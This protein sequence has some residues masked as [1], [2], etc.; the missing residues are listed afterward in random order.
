M[1][2]S[3]WVRNAADELSSANITNASGEARQIISAVMDVSLSGYVLILNEELPGDSL[4]R[5]ND[6]LKRRAGGEP[7]QYIIGKAPFFGRDFLVSPA[8]LIPRFDTETLVEAVLPFCRK[9]IDILDLC[10]GTGCVL[11]TVMLEGDNGM[12]GYGTDIFPGAVQLA[13]RNLGL[14]SEEI[15]KKC[16]K[17]S[18]AVKDLFGDIE[19]KYDIITANPP[20]IATGELD[21]LDAEVKDHEPMRALDGME[22]GLHFIREIIT[23]APCHLKENGILALETGYDQGNATAGLMRAAGFENVR[24]LRDPGG[25][26]RVVCGR[27]RTDDR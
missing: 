11:L 7:L 19:E 12:N 4:C 18:F 5:A 6:I 13:E 9:G 24:V 27:K 21:G 3:E 26:D 14:Y 22:D 10:T 23:G 20:Y 25:H 1:R 8:T 2:I 15:E 17:V 16:S